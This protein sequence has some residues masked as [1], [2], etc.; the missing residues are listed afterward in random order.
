LSLARRAATIVLPPIAQLSQLLVIPASMQRH[1][2]GQRA[3][4]L[5]CRQAQ[6]LAVP[7]VPKLR[8]SAAASH[9]GQRV[10]RSGRQQGRRLIGGAAEQ[11]A[12][13]ITCHSAASVIQD[14]ADIIPNPMDDEDDDD[15][16]NR[17]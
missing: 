9:D 2:L 10:P 5:V 8:I 13:R 15:D 7:Q 17:T 16:P 14:P 12:R 4:R 3:S 6:V 11:R 1:A